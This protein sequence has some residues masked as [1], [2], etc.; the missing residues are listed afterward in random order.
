MAETNAL[1]NA[2][3]PI[4]EGTLIGAEA[5]MHQSWLRILR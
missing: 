3:S 1:I 2:E 4:K 5:R